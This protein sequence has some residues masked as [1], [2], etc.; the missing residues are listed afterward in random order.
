MQKISENIII[1]SICNTGVPLLNVLLGDDTAIAICD[2]EKVLYYK[3]GINIDFKVKVG[4]P[5]SCNK[6]FEKILQTRSMFEEDI[7]SGKAVEDY[8]AEFKAVGYPIFEEDK[9]IG[10]VALTVS[11][12]N[13]RKVEKIIEDLSRSLEEMSSGIE[14]VSAGSVNLANMSSTLTN[15]AKEV[16]KNAD[17][18]NS[19]VG[20]IQ[21]ISSQTN[22]LGLNA[23]IEAAR[24]GEY[25][26]GFSVV[27]EEI[28]KLSIDSKESIDKIQGIINKITDSVHTINNSIDI[29]SE[30]SQI[31]SAALQQMSA[32]IQQLSATSETLKALSEGL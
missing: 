14:E 20:L 25:G 9:I 13:K 15:E 16:S 29:A 4:D 2:T 18:T 22:L 28:R 32:S 3:P 11:I 21:N 27:A 10:L 17:D 31:Q 24:A 6:N 8:G 23:S 19:I 1:N 5:I 12:R 7:V 26:R 30:V